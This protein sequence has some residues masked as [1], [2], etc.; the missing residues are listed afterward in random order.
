MIEMMMPENADEEMQP[1]IA[2]A[3]RASN[4]INRLTNSLLDIRAFEAGQPLKN[5]QFVDAVEPLTTA[6]SVV[7]PLA[8][9]K[10]QVVSLETNDIEKTVLID[11][12]MI[13]RVLTNLVENAVKYSPAKSHISIGIRHD[14]DSIAYF[15]EDNGPGIPEDQWRTI[16]N[17][18]SRLGNTG[19]GFGLGL[20]FCRLAVEAHEGKIWVEE[21]T[22]ETGSR[23]VFTLPTHETEDR[24]TGY[25]RS[26]DVNN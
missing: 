12:D 7:E 14:A 3:N 25:F 22:R 20:S 2:V 15:V 9:A 1:L 19:L 13:T 21:S 5:L 24:E 18:F 6:F 17:K 16:F 8:F 10:S 26:N 23:F 4:R 11:K